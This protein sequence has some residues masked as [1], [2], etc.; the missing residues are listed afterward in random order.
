MS[1]ANEAAFLILSIE[2]AKMNRFVLYYW[3]DKTS[4]LVIS[5]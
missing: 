1:K 4:G 5:F 3:P 2:P